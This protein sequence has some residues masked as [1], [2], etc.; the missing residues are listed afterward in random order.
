MFTLLDPSLEGTNQTSTDVYEL[1]LSYLSISIFRLH[2]LDRLLLLLQIE[3]FS[4]ENVNTFT[5]RNARQTPR[6]FK[7]SELA[8]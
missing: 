6:Y 5:K 1:G 2:G 8:C 3:Y 7:E 4:E